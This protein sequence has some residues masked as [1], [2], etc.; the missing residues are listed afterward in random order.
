MSIPPRFFDDLR[1]RL[2]LS[3]VI[4]KRIRV[5]RAGREYK[6]CCPFHKENTPSFTIN[7]AKQFYH[8]FGCGA[9]G[10]AIKFVMEHDNQEFMQ[11]VEILAAEAGMQVPQMSPKEAVKA[12]KQKTLYDLLEETAGWFQTQLFHPENAEILDYINKRGLSEDMIRAFR[13][14]F[15]PDNF[16]SLKEHL[17][18]LT[19][20]EDQMLAAGVLKKS[21]RD[22]KTYSFFRGRIITPVKDM[23]GRIVAFGGRILPDHMRPPERGD[24]TPPKYINS[25]ENEVFHKSRVLYGG[26]IARGAAGQGKPVIVTEGYFDVIA[27]HQAGFTGAVAPM[28][29]ALTEEQI[30]MLWKMIPADAGDVREPVLCFDGDNAGRRAAERA[31]KLILPMLEAG[32]SAR[33][34]FLPDGEDPDSL[35]KNAGAKAFQGVLNTAQPFFEFLWAGHTAGRSFKTPDSRAALVKALNK[36]IAEIKDGEVQRHYHSLIKD[37]IYKSFYHKQAQRGSSQNKAPLLP[38]RLRSPQANAQMV[39]VRILLACILN[40]PELYEDW[41]EEFGRLE[42][43]DSR[44]EMLR[45]AIIHVFHANQGLDSKALQRQ[46]KDGNCAEQLDDILSSRTYIHAKFCAPGQDPA[47]VKEKWQRLLKEIQSGT[48]KGEIQKGWKHAFQNADEQ[49]ENRLRTLLDQNGIM[50]EASE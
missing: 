15:A 8:C 21:N 48:V 22:A 3:D 17:K 46:I 33:F 49:E 37:R 34:A 27:C 16:D 14:G 43:S 13:I 19:Y 20:T 5:T 40:Y 32:R 30:L 12:E 31:C 6:A 41:E 18:S 29:T 11:A 28:G 9:H 35:I 23:R 2:T 39:K 7:D 50:R 10:D 36:D 45:Q 38:G 4:G 1:A 42:I 25:G 44:L 26:D 24:F 47:E